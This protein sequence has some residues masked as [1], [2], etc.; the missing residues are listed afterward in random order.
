MAGTILQCPY[1]HRLPQGK[2]V[3]FKAR[4]IADGLMPARPCHRN[5]GETLRQADSLALQAV[6]HQIIAVLDEIDDHSVLAP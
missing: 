1:W 5:A 6:V 3:Y 4:L 2:T